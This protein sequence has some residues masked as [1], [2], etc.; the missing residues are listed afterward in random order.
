MVKT[1][2]CQK[3]KQELEALEKAP[4]PGALGQKVLDSISKSAWKMWMS[5][6]TMLINEYRLNLLD[7]KSREYLETEM[8]KF[9]FEDVNEKP[10]GYIPPDPS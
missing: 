6:Q 10:S 8:K 4:Y 2:Y 5:H 7:P 1:V 9:L 3:L